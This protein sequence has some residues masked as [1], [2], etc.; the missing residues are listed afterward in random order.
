[1]L[2]VKLNIIASDV[3]CHSNDR[4]PIKLTNEMTCRNSIQ[5]GHYNV[6]KNQVIFGAVLNLVHS[7]QTIE[8]QYVNNDGSGYRV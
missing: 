2:E 3:G 6:H 4:R 1:M 7:F 8:L 5:I